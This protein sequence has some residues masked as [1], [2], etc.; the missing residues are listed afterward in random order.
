MVTTVIHNIGKIVSG[1]WN[2]G[3][4]KADTIRIVDGVIQQIGGYDE[5]KKGGADVIVDAN[6][7]TV[8]PGLIDP[9]THLSF[10]DFSPMQHMVGLLT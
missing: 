10:G 6:G 1:D 9:H 2:Q 5:V 4:L 3:V 8:T 7:M